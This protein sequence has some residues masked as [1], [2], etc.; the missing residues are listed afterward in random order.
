MEPAEFL[1]ICVRL[2]AG[3]EDRPIV[4]RINTQ[5]GFHKVGALRQLVSSWDKARLLG[6]DPDFTCTRNHLPT[7]KKRHEARHAH[8]K[9]NRSR[10]KIVVM[11]DV[12]VTVKI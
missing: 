6:F 11:T 2:V 8:S 9:G 1:R 12:T 10:Y 5:V 3:I 7:H 4:H